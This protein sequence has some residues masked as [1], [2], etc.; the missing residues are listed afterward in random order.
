MP[1][2]ASCLQRLPVIGGAGKRGP[3][4]FADFVIVALAAPCV[5]L[6]I[7]GYVLLAAA[8]IGNLREKFVPRTPDA[9]RHAPVES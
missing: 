6:V 3:A 1:V 8:L 9:N 4:M 2:A 5:A 7:S